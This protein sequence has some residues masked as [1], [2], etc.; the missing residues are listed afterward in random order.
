MQWWLATLAIPFALLVAI[1]W[2]VR[3]YNRL[4][5]HRLLVREA[6]S[7][8]DVQLKRRHDLIPNLVASVRG[9]AD[10]ERRVLDEVMQLR[11][12]AM[13]AQTPPDRQS[14]EAALSGAI[15]SLLVIAEAYP[16]LIS[17]QHYAELMTRLSEVE[18]DLQ[19]ARRYY[20]GTVRELNTRVESFPANLLAA[21]FGFHIEPFFTLDRLSEAHLPRVA[22][23]PH[24]TPDAPRTTEQ[25]NPPRGQET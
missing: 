5:R 10:H 8:I 15:G 13:H 18:D 21:M 22:L 1:G 6:F 9:V 17:D 3:T 14:N 19:S 11:S 24:A 2:A 16:Q 20:N 7:G 25:A 4:I 23:H 12:Q